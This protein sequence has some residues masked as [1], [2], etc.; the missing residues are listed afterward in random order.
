LGRGFSF[1]CSEPGAGNWI[2][3]DDVSRRI[4]ALQSTVT[5]L[6]QNHM[7]TSDQPKT[8]EAPTSY[9]IVPYPAASFPQ[10]HPNRI[11]A[12]ARLFGVNVAAPSSARVLELGCADGSNILPMAD[13][14]RGSTFL[15]IDASKVQ[16]AAGHKALTASGLKNVELRYQNILEFSAA[17]GKFDYI[18]VHG[19]FSWVPDSVREKILSI[20]STNLAENGIAY[21][22][23][24]TLPGW[25]M[26]RSL[27]DMSRFHTANLKDPAA[28]IQQTRALVKFLAESV[29]TEN[30]AYGMFL[31]NELEMMAKQQDN[32]L[33]HEILED[34]NQAFYFSEFLGR[35]GR[36]QL[37]YVGEP[38][39]A[40]M[41][42]GNFPEKVRETLQRIGQNVVAQEQYMDFLRNRTF[43]QT[44]LCHA[45][46]P[47]N[48]QVHGTATRNFAF[49]SLFKKQAGP[50]DLAPDVSAEF[51]SHAGTKVNTA[52]PFV[53]AMLVALT[54]AAPSVISY[55]D[56]LVAARTASR[57]IYGAGVSRDAVDET[58][59]QSNLMSLCAKG[60]IELYAEPVNVSST[61]PN[62]PALS[63]LVRYSAKTA[64]LVTNQ[65]HYGIGADVLARQVMEECDG[66][67]TPDDITTAVIAVVQ[68]GKINVQEG[69]KPVKDEKRL[70]ELVGPQVNGVLQKLAQNAYFPAA[71]N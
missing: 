39:L 29:A 34:D 40:Q 25:N 31:K 59:L 33:M 36:H 5:C 51:E 65:L 67:R 71:S 70:R 12:I 27:R 64:R 15:G 38:S 23:Y 7:S 18:I 17:E 3:V 44:I 32:Y 2:Y 37:Q 50:I 61:V 4:A 53:K 26:R 41:L 14:A 68:A 28:K 21:V 55:Q 48:R 16:I 47:I 52:D 19:I 45:K 58:T 42:A 8:P 11:G 60:F 46:A 56:L 54:N 35:A 13:H 20:C 62:K 9:D 43:R 6:L 49:Q 57:P 63:P 22:S 24:N 66:S 30:S 69:D 1:G 10:S